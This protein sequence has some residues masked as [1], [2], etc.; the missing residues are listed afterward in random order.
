MRISDWSSDVCSSDLTGMVGEFPELQ[1][2][3]GRYYALNDG[4]TPAAADAIAQH[5]QP[6]GPTDACPSAP[7]SVCVA[8]ADNIDTLAVFW[9]TDDKPTGS[10]APSPLT[11]PA[12]GLIRVHDQ[13]KLTHQPAK[14]RV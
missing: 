11:R 12:Q 5:Y 7:V 10:T 3:M 2:V 14:G 4:E 1:G 9:M 6:L 13:N 8:L